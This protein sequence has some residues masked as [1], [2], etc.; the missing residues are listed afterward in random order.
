MKSQIEKPSRRKARQLGPAGRTLSKTALKRLEKLQTLLHRQDQNAWAIGDSLI[1]LVESHRIPLR[2][3]SEHTGFSRSRL[4]EWRL[5]AKAFPV[6]QRRG[7]S[8]QD[9]LLA[10]LVHDR[11]KTLNLSL[12]DIRSEIK[13]LRITRIADAKRHFVQRLL[14]QQQNEAMVKGIAVESRNGQLINALHHSDYRKVISKL[15]KGSVKLFIAD[16]PFGGYSWREGGGYASGRSDTSGFRYECDNSKTDEAMKVTLDLFKACRSKIAEG[17][18]LLLFQPGG[19]PDRPEILMEA[20]KQEWECRHA[21]SWHKTNVVNPCHVSEPYGISTERLLVF[22]RRG[23]TLQWHERDLPRSDVLAFK[24]E[25]KRAHQEMTQGERE[26][27]DMFVFQKPVELMAFLVRKHTFEGELVVEPFGGSGS[28][29]IAAS[30][31]GRRWVYCESNATTFLW[32]SQR[33]EKQLQ[34]EVVSVG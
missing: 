20:Q 27:G 4:C 12:F 25:T 32:T 15:P 30:R 24:S 13:R 11:F 19:K 5:T 26:F 8:F 6:N 28:A 33:I 1:P 22:S 17:G 18:C 23:E 9:C 34:T 2:S 29:V 10:R 14:S 16:P 31:L 21:L 3:L 7:F